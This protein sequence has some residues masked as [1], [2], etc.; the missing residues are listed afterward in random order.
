MTEILTRVVGRGKV[1]KLGSHNGATEETQLF[2]AAEHEVG[3]SNI[4]RCKD[5]N[6]KERSFSLNDLIA[7][8]AYKLYILVAFVVITE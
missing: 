4:L 8:S 1:F 2:E 3:Q 7:C 5:F 6:F